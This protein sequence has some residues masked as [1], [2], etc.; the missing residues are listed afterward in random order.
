[1][2]EWKGEGIEE[3]MTGRLGRGGRDR[4]EEGEEEGREAQTH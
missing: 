3:E 4:K 1:M 2:E